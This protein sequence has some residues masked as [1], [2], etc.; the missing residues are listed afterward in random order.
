M[1]RFLIFCIASVLMNLEPLDVERVRRGIAALATSFDLIYFPEVDSTNRVAAL[2]PDVSFRPGVAVLTDYQS[3]GRGRRDRSWIAPPRSGLLMSLV[4]EPP[5]IPG[6]ALLLVALAVSDAL[7][8]AG[9]A[10]QIKWPN[11]VLTEGRKVCGILAESL[12]RDHSHFVVVG[13]GINVLA[14]PDLPGAGSVTGSLGRPVDREDLAVGVFRGIDRWIGRLA[15]Y[16]DA[17]FEE[18][19][20]RL[21]MIGSA[22]VV[23]DEGEH[24]AGTAVGVERTGGLR[25]R[26]AS[27][28]ERIF[29]AGDVSIRTEG[30]LQPPESRL[31]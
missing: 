21:D 16:P 3:A 23:S 19:V 20:A 7:R 5:P 15:K 10:P 12:A 28:G 6:D 11:D 31:Q 30:A 2:L 22:I 4:F 27:G 26:L 13:C 29:L 1:G 9:D 8:A 17:V 25:V 14:H 24:L 18:W